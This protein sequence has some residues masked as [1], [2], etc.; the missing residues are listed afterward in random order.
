MD[1]REVLKGASALAVAGAAMLPKLAFAQQFTLPAG[2]GPAVM[3]ALPGK[4]ALIRKTI[5]PP[6]YETPVSVFK[7][8]FTPNDSFFVRYH[9]ANIPD[10]D[11]KTWKLSIGGPSAATPVQFSLADLQAMEQVEVAAVCQCSGNRRGWS[12]PHVAGVEW[13]T[14]AMGNARWRGVRLKDLLAKAGMAKDLLE[15]LSRA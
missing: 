4:A 5:R 1:R 6:N 15:V 10:V 3:A 8:A 7:Q 12:D 13:G 2:A 9:L 11:A 14:G